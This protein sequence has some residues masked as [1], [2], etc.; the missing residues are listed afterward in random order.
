MILF[1]NTFFSV[2]FFGIA[3]K[4]KKKTCKTKNAYK[5][6]NCLTQQHAVYFKGGAHF[7]SWPLGKEKAVVAFAIRIMLKRRLRGRHTR[8]FKVPSKAAAD[9]DKINPQTRRA[10]R[11]C[12]R[13]LCRRRRSNLIIMLEMAP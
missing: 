9:G 12:P 6:L 13:A 4:I 1:V 10:G 5:K 11:I 8:I 7:S 3:A 2:N